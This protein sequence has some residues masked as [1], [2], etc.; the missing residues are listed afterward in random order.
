MTEFT[1]KL[2]RARARL[3]GTAATEF[4]V[5][6]DVLCHCGAHVLG[7]RTSE[8]QQVVCQNCGS[9]RY[10]LPVNV[11]PTT[12][13]VP[14]EVLGGSFRSRLLTVARELL[15]AGRTGSG[16]TE[17]TA[18]VQ[19]NGRAAARYS[20]RI[21]NPSDDPYVDGQT[22]AGAD[23]TDAART[24]DGRS[25][26]ADDASGGTM[27]ARDGAVAVSA[28]RRRSRG[29]LARAIRRKVTPFRLLMLG[30]ALILAM[31]GWWSWRQHQLD[32][33][34]RAWREGRD[35]ADTALNAGELPELE[36]ALQDLVNAGRAL[37]R[38]DAE[39]HLADN[40]LQQ[41][42]AVRKLNS[43]DMWE[44][45]EAAYGVDGSADPGAA[46][47][48]ENAM[49][50]GWYIFDCR[51]LTDAADRD[52]VKLDLPLD[53]R[54]DSVQILLASP[55]MQQAA[56]TLGGAPVLFAARVQTCEAPAGDDG[57]WTIHLDPGT[58]ALM[59]SDVH[60]AAAGLTAAVRPGLAAQLQLQQKF[61][62]DSDLTRLKQEQPARVAR[63]ET[64]HE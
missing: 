9:V 14:S 8:P 4:P 58:C 63:S 36:D 64:P 3:R 48:A 10:I 26:Q 55:L 22:G 2:R 54:G 49:G 12:L 21:T 62:D 61:L 17:T 56:V 1:T 11:Y 16:R 44:Q 18:E 46:K 37:G 39:F 5:P 52:L 57:G 29:D 28:K 59:T 42:R 6:Y 20:S 40:L 50:S 43:N 47:L 51:L 7:I 13:R 30:A 38:Q 24:D 45:L 31:T 23:G 32:L 60:A 34:R 41:T 35:R 19:P 15:P 27:R 33:A 25:I 53:V